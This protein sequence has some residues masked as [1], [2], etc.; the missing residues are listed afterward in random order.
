MPR[1]NIIQT[2]FTK[3]E[4]SPLAS[5]RVDV[6]LYASGAKSSSNF[7]I[8][9]Q[10]ALSRRSGTKRV[11]STRFPSQQSVLVQFEVSDE[12]AYMLEFGAGYI[13]F[14]KDK[15]TL[16]NTTVANEID[17]FT[18]ENNG[19]C[20][21]IVADDHNSSPQDAL[22]NF[23]GTVSNNGGLYRVTTTVPH[24]LRT[25]QKVYLYGA[26]AYHTDDGEYTVTR[27]SSTVVDIQSS[28]YSASLVSAY[29]YTHGLMAGDRFFVSGGT[30][31]S[32]LGE[33]HHTVKSV[34]SYFEFTVA[35]VAYSGTAITGI[36]DN[37]SGE[38]RITSV[39]HGKAT[40]DNITISDASTFSGANGSWNITVIDADT[41]DL[42]G[43]TFGG[44]YSSGATWVPYPTLEEAHTIPIEISTSFT[45]NELA[46]IRFCQSAD[47]LYIVHPDHPPQ[48]LMRLTDDG[49]RDD[50]LLVDISF[51]DGPYLA[52][53][54]LSPNIN[55]T[56]PANGAIYRD[57]YMEIS[58]Y[59]HTATV[60]SATAFDAGGADDGKYIEYRVGDQW[61]LALLPS[62]T[63]GLTTV[64]GVTII[65]NVLLY[66]D[67][68]T[69][70]KSKAV[71]NGSDSR[72]LDKAR[73]FIAED[74]A[75]RRRLT[76]A[77]RSYYQRIVSDDT[78]TSS[79]T[80]SGGVLPSGTITSQYSNTFSTSD[81]G[82]F[83]R[84]KESTG[85]A[86]GY[87]AQITK[88]GSNSSGNSTA[89]HAKSVDM[90]SNNATGKF[91]ITNDTRTATVTSKQN[92]STFA[93]F[94]STDVGRMIRLGFA[95]R[96]TWGKITGYTS[97]SQVTVTFYADMPRD[98]H[99]AENI[100]GNQNSASANSGIT[101][102]WRLGAW[103]DTT[104][105]PEV[106]CFQEQR[107]VFAGTK[108]TTQT[109]WM[110]IAGDF[111][112]FSPTEPDS[113]VLDDNAI[114]Y[115][116]GSSKANAIKWLMPGSALTIGTTGGEWQVRAATSIND[117]LTPSN[118]SAKEYTTH[119]SLGT[120]FPARIGSS[121][122]FVDRS[123]Q[124]VREL[125]YSY[126]KDAL[127]SDD[128]T[129]ISEH[130]LR[131]HNNAVVSAFQQKPHSI[132]WIV[133]AD[134]TLSA[135]TFNKS[136]EVVAWHNHT[137]GNGTVEDIAV[138]PSTDG[139]DEVWL[140]VNR[141][142]SGADYRS[143]EVLEPDYYRSG[144][145]R[146]DMRFLDCHYVVDGWTSTS[147]SGL[148]YLEGL[149]V[150]PVV[151]GVVQATK[152][153][154]SGA[155]TL[156]SGATSEVVIGI[157]YTSSIQSLPPEGGSSFGTSQGAIKRVV[158]FSGRFFDSI[159]VTYGPDSTAADLISETLPAPASTSPWF[160]GTYRM[161]PTNGYDIENGWYIEQ[162][163]PYPLNLLFV[164][165]RLET[166]E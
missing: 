42:D 142:I 122:V 22:P 100:A 126:E 15:E 74:A 30:N 129:V 97:T 2:A 67:E 32:N 62:G 8:R 16:Y 84:I 75:G 92:G 11:R 114:T 109:F 116:L 35:N 54:D 93:A 26:G 99:N 101:Y 90:A 86:V 39:A 56:T 131:S 103:S 5:G 33:K 106:A 157:A 104:G 107:L 24:T 63:N 148:N 105:Y 29:I 125:F 37:G 113:S 61:A 46:D 12:Q 79:S 138:I 1:Q 69:K 135:M 83:V 94:A 96:W 88:I 89:T 128:L 31:F 23:L 64:N 117:P 165:T 6:N 72:D 73:F 80:L 133:C 111:E 81:V 76:S 152:T 4:V 153:V 25:G 58:S 49:D 66:L 119:G 115:T 151:D 47:V 136:Q 7:L 34:E 57:V 53:N 91:I 68:T 45:E 41:F 162:S 98:P 144:T 166:N 163:S 59:A 139:M 110:S 55:T 44:T 36:A 164:V 102:D 28:T 9:P 3:G 149:T 145:S 132:Y 95:G 147:I 140:I 134:G 77:E 50:W 155:I 127:D 121:I 146:L 52:F 20:I 160:S 43:S 38:F 71:N 130:I 82:K 40:N 17:F 13:H 124:K 141:T 65:D 48:K 27:I 21:Q 150:T 159:N 154:T 123:G 120:A 60:K 70:L 19:G 85:T 143:V 51:I 137:I 108:T 18:V 156:T 161:V 87:W 10:G 112:A 118:I 158:D 14:Y 78:L